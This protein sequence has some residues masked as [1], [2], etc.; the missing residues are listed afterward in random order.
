MIMKYIMS[1]LF[2]IVM[3][4][5]INAGSVD[6]IFLDNLNQSLQQK[7]ELGQSKGD[8]IGTAFWLGYSIIRETK[9]NHSFHAHRTSSKY[10]SLNKMIYGTE[11]YDYLGNSDSMRNEL[12]ILILFDKKNAITDVKISDME[13]GVH[14]KKLPLIWLGAHDDHMASF[15]LQKSIYTENKIVDIREDLIVVLSLHQL[16]PDVKDFLVD[17]I[18]NENDQDLREEAVFWL[19]QQNLPEVT[20]YLYQLANNDD[21]QEI[22]EKA[23]FALS[24]LDNEQAIDYVIDLAQN[25]ENHDVRKNAIFWLGQIASEKANESLQDIIYNE[26]EQELKEQAIFALSQLPDNEGVSPLIKIATNHENAQLRKKAIFWLGQTGDPRALETIISII[27][28][29]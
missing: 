26:N 7:W 1:L 19:G 24:Q 25:S 10:T 6:V 14:L 8:S 16:Q 23:V 4:F 17:I 27:K 21:A 15:N 22:R 12:G 3:I 11:Y 29:D 28:T 2:I 5:H 13:S 9:R 20:E 18:E